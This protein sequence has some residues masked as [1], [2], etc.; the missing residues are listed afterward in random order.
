V[1][2]VSCLKLVIW[3]AQ[4]SLNSYYPTTQ[5]DQLHDTMFDTMLIN[6]NA[7]APY[8]VTPLP[9]QTKVVYPPFHIPN[10]RTLPI[11]PK[12]KPAVLK[13]RQP[14][15]QGSPQTNHNGNQET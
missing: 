9:F 4:V 5:A 6:D 2:D 12:H 13:K 1:P 3:V 14:F 11:H 15:R 10:A 7:Q 8:L